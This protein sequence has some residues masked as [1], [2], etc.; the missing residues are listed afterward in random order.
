[1]DI[2]GDQEEKILET[3]IIRKLQDIFQGLNTVNNE[4]M[5]VRHSLLKVRESNNDVKMLLIDLSAEVKKIADKLGNFIQ[6]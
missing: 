1:M 2:P 4:L 6:A 5:M 3:N